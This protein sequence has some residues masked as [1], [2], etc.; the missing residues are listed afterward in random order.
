MRFYFA[1]TLHIIVQSRGILH[2]WIEIVLLDVPQ[3]IVE[4]AL[5]DLSCL[6]IEVMV[7]DLVFALWELFHVALNE[8]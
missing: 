8:G 5:W 2:V 4:E 7:V 6:W 3:Q 1:W